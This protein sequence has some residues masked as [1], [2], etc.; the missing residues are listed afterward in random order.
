MV[1][2][3]WLFPR[4]MSLPN[5][6]DASQPC[7]ATKWHIWFNLVDGSFY[8]MLLFLWWSYSKI[9]LV[10]FGVESGPGA[11]I[12]CK[13]GLKSL[14]VLGRMSQI[15]PKFLWSN[16]S[17]QSLLQEWLVQAWKF[18][19]PEFIQVINFAIWNH[20]EILYTCWKHTEEYVQEIWTPCVLI[21]N[22]QLRRRLEL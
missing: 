11:S 2:Q 12:L 4:T 19:R 5:L 17:R 22:L 13:F 10:K 21:H 1:I 20:I 9:T 6:S 16:G 18:T 7:D 15:T 8:I 3:I 14:C